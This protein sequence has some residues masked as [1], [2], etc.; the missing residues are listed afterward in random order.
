M[1]PRSLA[2][3]A[4]AAALSSNSMAA[5]PAPK[6]VPPTIV[7]G[8]TAFALDLYGRLRSEPGNVFLSPASISTA[9]SMTYAGARGDTAKQMAKVLHFGLPEAQHHEGQGALL[10][11]LSSPQLA[12]ANRIYSQ[13][14]MTVEAPFSK[15][16]SDHYG[17]GMELLDF[18]GKPDPSRL[19]INAWVKQKTHDKIVDLL[20]PGVI[21]SLTR[22]VLTNAIYFK[23]S[24]ATAFPKSNTKDDAF[25]N[26]TATKKV[27][28][29]HN[30][31]DARFATTADAQVLELPYKASGLSMVVVLPKAKDGLGKVEASLNAANVDK[32]M[33]SLGFARVDVALPRF[34][35]T[36]SFELSGTLSSMGMPLPFTEGAADFTGIHKKGGLHISK[37]VHKAFVDVNEEGTEAAAATAVVI[38]TE[39]AAVPQPPVPFRADHP[40]LFFIRDTAT[41]TILF[42]GRV[43][44]PA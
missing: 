40:F 36:R 1:K 7:E 21:T 44:E 42:M 12:I 33:K 22:M 14:G 35:M 38:A 10:A 30:V 13:N 25:A 15:V 31:L 18:A 17:A 28:T 27:P 43:T 6:P 5:P 41:N 32:L 16:T 37:V 24:W 9:L 4:V 23:G 2:L 3:A 39:S 11:R 26:G 29:M 20:A 8:N 34:S 19:T